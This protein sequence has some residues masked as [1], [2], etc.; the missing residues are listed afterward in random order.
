VRTGSARPVTS[1]IKNRAVRLNRVQI[2]LRRNIEL[3][4]SLLVIGIGL[5]FTAD[6]DPGSTATGLKT[7]PFAVLDPPQFDLR[8]SRGRLELSATTASRQ[9]E[10]DLRSI[11]ARLFADRQAQV[12]LTPGIR[13]PDSWSVTTTSLLRALAVAESADATVRDQNI[14]VRGVTA[15]PVEFAARL[16]AV[17]DMLPTGTVIDQ[18]M[19]ALATSASLDTLCSQAFAEIV[20]EPVAFE[21]SSAEI[22]TSSYSMLD[23]LID[24][25][26]DCQNQQVRITGH[27]D[28]SGDETW[29]RRLSR[30]RAQS[31]A[32]YLARG[33]IEVGRLQVDGKGSS[34]PVA[35]N[36]TRLGRS[37]NR[38]IEFTLVEPLL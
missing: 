2:V 25:A 38:R 7:G 28:A 5:L 13:V 15:D 33:G 14:T 34:E 37:L 12:L 4:L 19:T 27:T 11:V 6:I 8:L 16:G 21:Q 10:S 18:D 29:N 36:E 22:K 31:V 17:R 3:T 9:H 30:L 1:A 23:K 24:F 20:A 35:D 26:Y 32:D